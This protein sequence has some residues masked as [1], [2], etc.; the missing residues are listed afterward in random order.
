MMN[1]KK[2]H[3]MRWIIILLAIALVFLFSYRAYVH[4]SDW[5]MY[6]NYFNQPNQKI[7]SWMSIKMVSARFNVSVED[8][9][10]AAGANPQKVNNHMALDRFCIEYNQNCTK[11]I[12][13]LNNLTRK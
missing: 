5:K 8:I 11:L 10:S 2:N 3:Y 1:K 7:E 6:H 4:Y 13:R 12:E 9:F